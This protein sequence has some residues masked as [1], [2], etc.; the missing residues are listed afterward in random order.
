MKFYRL[1][2]GLFTLYISLPW[3]NWSVDA[4]RTASIVR[5]GT[6]HEIDELEFDDLSEIDEQ[7]LTN[8]V[9][10]DVNTATDL[11]DNYA[12]NTSNDITDECV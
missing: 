7:V 2:I 1:A 12:L 11:A 4:A 9:D 6:I 5:L 8:A 3:V 10:F